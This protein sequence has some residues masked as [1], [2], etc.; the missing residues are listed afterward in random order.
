MR[1]RERAAV[2]RR[3]L[4]H[5]LAAQEAGDFAADREAQARAAEFASRAHVFLLE[6]FEDDFVF[7]GLDADAGIDH[8]KISP[9][10]H[11]AAR[12][13]RRSVRDAER[14]RAFLR[15]LERVGE[16]VLENLHQT[17]AVGLDAFRQTFRE[18]NA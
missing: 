4:D 9:R 16:Q 1:E 5:D 10:N 14:H 12:I 6:G 11:V 15:E 18:L 13:C 3:A 2:A 17:H 7:V 8:R